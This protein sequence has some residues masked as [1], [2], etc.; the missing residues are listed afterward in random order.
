LLSSDLQAQVIGHVEQ[1]RQSRE[2][3]AGRLSGKFQSFLLLYFLVAT[4]IIILQLVGASPSSKYSS[5]FT[6]PSGKL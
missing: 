5:R 3:K 4:I 6:D 1:A 2:V